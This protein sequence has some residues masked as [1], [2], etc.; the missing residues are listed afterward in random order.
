MLEEFQ[1][2]LLEIKFHLLLETWEKVMEGCMAAGL[3]TQTMEMT[4]QVLIPL[5]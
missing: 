1:G 5:C 2:K 4:H 3:V